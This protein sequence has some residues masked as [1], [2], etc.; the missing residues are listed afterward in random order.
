MAIKRCQSNITVLQAAKTRIKNVFNNGLPVYMSFSGGK[1][2]LCLS[3]LV[4]NL[5][6]TGEINPAQ[7]IVQFIDEEAIFP[8]MEA[9]VREWRKKFILV[10]ATF[11]W[12]CLEVKHYNCFNELSN[13]ETFICWDSLK[14]DVWVRTPPSFSIRSH[15]LLRPRIDS[16]Q[17]FLPRTCKSGIVITGVRVAE[18]FQRLQY[19]A[20]VN[21][22][23][24]NMTSKH[25]VYPI[26][27]WKDKDVWLYLKEQ[28]VDIPDIYLYLW[29]S[30]SNRKQ[31]RVSQF[32]SVDT[33]RSL[34]K[35]NEY[36][37]N[38]MERIIKREPNAYLAALYWDSE[39]F[40]RSSKK[41]R[42]LEKGVEKDYKHEL[43]KL[44]SNMDLYFN[45]PHKRK[46]AE[47]YRGFFLKFSSIVNQKE[48]KY[49]Y[50]GLISG[51]PKSRTLRA[52]YQRIYGRYVE[53]AKKMEAGKI[54][55][56]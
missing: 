43:L 19:I 6:Q 32:F 12:Y 49:I 16:Y 28:K 34:V 45:T 29:Q 4:M 48:C 30:G 47:S 14:K 53:E 2:S 1:D 40:G 42:E 24:R 13:D 20:I 3:Q 21:K 26:Y 17:D 56:E 11:E 18:S 36:Y 23:G 7:L 46:I 10:G 55:R 39:M 9:K 8:C 31:L 44:F 38:L 52:L 54:G 27:D 41:R 35:M 37:P 50:E 5:I 33:A 22:T 51:D 15:P 25:Y